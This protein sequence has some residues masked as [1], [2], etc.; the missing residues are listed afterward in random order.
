MSIVFVDQVIRS[1]SAGADGKY[2]GIKVQHLPAKCGY[3][4]KFIDLSARL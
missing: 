2:L 4:S 1:P 3:P